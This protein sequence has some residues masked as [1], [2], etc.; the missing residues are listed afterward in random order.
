MMRDDYRHLV[1]ERALQAC[2]TTN[3]PQTAKLKK[4]LDVSR[5]RL[6]GFSYTP[7]LALHSAFALL[8]THVLAFLPGRPRLAEALL[9]VCIE[10][11]ADI[12][13]AVRQILQ[14]QIALP[15]SLP[16]VFTHEQTP[17][18]LI[19]LIDRIH[20]DHPEYSIDDIT[21]LSIVLTGSVPSEMFPH[22][23]PDLP[24]APDTLQQPEPEQSA[25]RLYKESAMPWQDWLEQ[26]RLFPPEDA[27]WEA[28]EVAAFT[29]EVE[30]LAL[31]KREERQTGLRALSA[32]LATLQTLHL[33][34]LGFIIGNT[35]AAQ[36]SADRL[37]RYQ[38][39]DA[40][41]QVERLVQLLS[42]YAMI[43]QRAVTTAAARRQLDSELRSAEDRIT[44][45]Y[46]Q[47]AE[48]FAETDQPPQPDDDQHSLPEQALP[49]A[50]QAFGT[51]SLEDFETSN[52]TDAHGQSETNTPDT[53]DRTDHASELVEM[54]P[55][56]ITSMPSAASS[57]HGEL[58]KIDLFGP[59][60]PVQEYLVATDNPIE[61]KPLDE[62]P[63]TLLQGD[64][65]GTPSI[66][67]FVE[68]IDTD[69]EEESSIG[70]IASHVLKGNISQQKSVLETLFWELL[71]ENQ[72]ALAYHLALYMEADSQ[73][74]V[75]LVPELVRALILAPIVRHDI[76]DIS[77]Q[78]KQAYDVFSTKPPE[79]SSH[80]REIL[81]F[82][83]SAATLRPA[84]LAPSSG[85]PDVLQSIPAISGMPKLHSYCQAIADYSRFQQ[86]LDLRLL[87]FANNRAAWEAEQEKLR[88]RVEE[89]CRRAMFKTISYKPAEK[90][91]QRWQ[92]DEGL[93]GKLLLPIRQN[94]SIKANQTLELIK[95][96]TD[97]KL[98]QTLVNTTDRKELGR[99]DGEDI[100]GDA[101][102]RLHY[103]TNEAVSFAR[104][105]LRLLEA[106]PNSNTNFFQQK[107]QDLHSKLLN[108][109]Q[110]VLYELQQY[111]SQELPDKQLVY[112]AIWHFKRAFDSVQSLFSNH[113]PIDDE[114]I[115]PKQIINAVLLRSTDIGINEAWEPR[116]T[117]DQIGQALLGI[118]LTLHYGWDK[119][120]QDW[121]NQH[122]H[123]ATQQ[124][125]EAIQ[126]Q[127]PNSD[128][129][130]QLEIQRHQHLSLCRDALKREIKQIYQAIEAPEDYGPLREYHRNAYIA[131]LQ[132][133]E[134]KISSILQFQTASAQLASI[135]SE[136]DQLHRVQIQ[137]AR[138]RLKNA[139]IDHD[140]PAYIRIDAALR[141]G[142]SIVAN[143]YIEMTRKGE[144]LPE[145]S[146][147]QDIFS[148]F[149]RDKF[150]KII[151]NLERA[152]S[153]LLSFQHNQNKHANDIE[154]DNIWLFDRQILSDIHAKQAA[155]L[156][157]IW[158]RV[159]QAK[160]IDSRNASNILSNLGF[161]PIKL[162]PRERGRPGQ[163]RVTTKVLQNKLL[164]PVWPYGSGADGIYHLLCFW[165]GPTEK[166]IISALE[167][168]NSQQPVIVFYFELMT[169][170]RRKALAQLCHE[171]RVSCV[172]LDEA[173][174]I[175][176]CTF[177]PPRLPILFD[178][179]L[180]FTYLDPYT[181]TAG[182]VPAEMFY[183]RRSERES[184][185]NPMGSCFIYGGRQLG[186][187]ALLRNIE[188]E[189]HQPEQGQIVIWIDLKAERIGNERSIDEIWG[190]IARELSQFDICD[191]RTGKVTADWMLRHIHSWLEGD[192]QRRILL[193]LDEADTFLSSDSQT[194]TVAGR[195]IDPFQRA[196]L[197][198]GL[199][200]RTN[201]RFK[202]VFAG[203][204]NVQRT[205]RDSNHPLA[206]Y[207]TPICIG[208]LLDQGEWREAR[209]L[210]EQPL[211][212]LGY[213]F[214]SPDLVTRILSQTNYYP[215][216]IQ[217]Y[218]KQLIKH[219]TTLH[220]KLEGPPY[221][222]TRQHVEDV[223][224]SQSL[225]DDI[226]Q[227]F[228]LTIQLD[229]RYEVLAYA[230]A[231]ASLENDNNGM[232]EGFPISWFRG[233]ALTWWQAGFADSS[234]EDQIHALL[235][236]MVGLG[237]LR[238]TE[239]K[240][241]ALRSPNVMLLLGDREKIET[242]LLRDREPPIRYE[243]ETFRA[244]LHSKRG[245]NPIELFRRS[246]LTAMQESALTERTNGISIICGCLGSGRTDIETFLRAAAHA[247]EVKTISFAHDRVGFK[248]QLNELIRQRDRES[249]HV[250]LVSPACPWSDTWIDDAFEQLRALRSNNSW[251]R[252]AFIA[253]PATSWRLLQQNNVGIS[254]PL[255][256][257]ASLLTLRP[258]D[259]AA[260]RQ[261]LEELGFNLPTQSERQ[262]LRAVTGYWPFLLGRFY[263]ATHRDKQY[264]QQ[265]LDEIEQQMET[266]DFQLMLAEQF[267]LPANPALEKL[268]TIA[269][270]S[271]DEPIAI[272]M[273]ISI[274]EQ[275]S[276]E[277]VRLSLRWAALLGFVIPVGNNQL[278]L[279]PIVRRAL[280]A[281][282]R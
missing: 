30:R 37:P 1:V 112:I 254:D 170:A 10:A 64:L 53:L 253:D 148:D 169:E 259:D 231:T 199:M 117:H 229:R 124:V 200:D 266:V 161:E 240:R 273:L 151:H 166:E 256:R 96:L 27:L 6:P 250:F 8:H 215:S 5:L 109:Q 177:P 265:A 149:F 128:L 184:I 150:R 35:A 217:L 56:Q 54:Q 29:A 212:S 105:W 142:N 198:K 129:V 247:V 234:A 108:L 176:L 163:Y 116:V 272:D 73:L 226:L 26:L 213:H 31:H 118:V 178:C 76:G 52:A 225:R 101:L 49:A 206:H 146:N 138:R 107:V 171:R 51:T 255:H 83:W 158:D 46:E 270:L 67:Q 276:P 41:A 69:L 131:R 262:R 208:P 214:D 43:S 92:R 228:N 77:L 61:I 187:T 114:E 119:I 244:A 145:P 63:Q 97:H 28:E 230:V 174:L 224:Q 143:E 249:S 111:T 237:I 203:L 4:A 246:P 58:I 65:T 264:W 269:L 60:E 88:Q 110:S 17:G 72:V 156:I 242:E 197:I 132:A 113:L 55:A 195:Q 3:T 7:S 271:G 84:L 257:A 167:E 222:I 243:R 22:P 252:V 147:N 47:L 140:N 91:W 135:H 278:R 9:P 241:Y 78:L 18:Q 125:I 233:Q 232:V 122:D 68:T 236:E 172:V 85:A 227:R 121:C 155:N 13:K 115:P 181:T 185:L 12:E 192:R 21:L 223:Y 100:H 126:S 235:D 50:A 87:H 70:S 75:P 153:T 261:W 179:T 139:Q 210:I 180:P 45:I 133:V 152:H 207:G 168:Q 211:A 160:L 62:P 80:N 154:S 194:E 280:E 89:W 104:E 19:Q 238:Q 40:A 251:V 57:S 34:D 94:N 81:L 219:M 20:A 66:P 268:R 245:S 11:M 220:T 42:E 74:G 16:V 15:D 95:E 38:A 183:G 274:L 102:Q 36:W 165:D 263:D 136:I 127:H 202:V 120:F 188:S 130:K 279:D 23:D 99:P 141:E 24:E 193:L 190:V 162:E 25:E 173:L 33:G 209:R 282:R 248:E 39:A 275:E 93:I 182:I 48:L 277:Q 90:V 59:E 189:A 205:T 260:V 201:R 14:Q 123:L 159:K 79:D 281:R 239:G 204:H 218:C 98:F 137:N 134:S 191:K 144:P 258:W 32:A 106:K 186:K 267:E 103:H 86:P 216:L 44:G 164:C 157:Q 221:T 196:S 2:R 82:L 175:Y 71:R